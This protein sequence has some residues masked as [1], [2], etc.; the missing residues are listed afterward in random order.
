MPGVI[1]QKNQSSCGLFLKRERKRKKCALGK[2]KVGQLGMSGGEG[3][4]WE[5]LGQVGAEDEYDQYALH[6]ILE[7]YIESLF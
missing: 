4:I 2:H 6:E 3:G 5:E 7:E 1:R